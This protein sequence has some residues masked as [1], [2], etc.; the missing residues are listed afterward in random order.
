M[1][2]SCLQCHGDPADAP[3]SLLERYG[4]VA[5]FH[6]PLSQVIALDTVAI[7]LEEKPTRL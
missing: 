2:E 3:K 5:G 7:P 4:S 1:E 6:R